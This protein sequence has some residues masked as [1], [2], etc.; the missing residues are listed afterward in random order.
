[1]GLS[2][3]EWGEIHFWVAVGLALVITIHLAL[4]W[5]WIVSMLKGKPEGGSHLRLALG[6]VGIITLLILFLGPFVLSRELVLH[7]QDKSEL[8]KP[9]CR[10]QN[11]Q[12]QQSSCSSAP[13]VSGAQRKRHPK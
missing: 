6:L 12:G 13:H 5:K 9:E 7:T 11:A 3:H 10:E 1:M 4:H 8:S 2:R